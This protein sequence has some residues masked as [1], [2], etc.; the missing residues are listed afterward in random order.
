MDYDISEGPLIIRGIISA[1]G[2][3]YW[4]HR[5]LVGS[6][7]N[8]CEM[9]IKVNSCLVTIHGVLQYIQLVLHMSAAPDKL[10]RRLHPIIIAN[11]YLLSA[12]PTHGCQCRL[13]SPCSHSHTRTSTT[14]DS[15]FLFALTLDG[16]TRVM[17]STHRFAI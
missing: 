6:H 8:N 2:M 17:T 15:T 7:T 9:N 3:A 5:L 11:L 12:G 13:R 16:G 14:T 1:L 4:G 10:R